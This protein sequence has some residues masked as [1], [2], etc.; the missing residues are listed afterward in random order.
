M[1]AGIVLSKRLLSPGV[2]VLTHPS[3][4][5]SIVEYEPGTL[6]EI[7]NDPELGAVLARSAPAPV[8][9]PPPRPP[10]PPRAPQAQHVGPVRTLSIADAVREHRGQPAPVVDPKAGAQVLGSI[11][12]A[13]PPDVQTG[14]EH[15]A[16]GDELGELGELASIDDTHDE[17][18]AAEGNNPG[19]DGAR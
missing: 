2:V 14:A 7:R 1:A 15:A 19:T 17:P 10:V 6:C 16:I 11:F 3:G 4:A 5:R 18:A 9:P 8:A 13:L 12:E